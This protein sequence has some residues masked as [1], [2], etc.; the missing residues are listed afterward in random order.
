[1]RTVIGALI[2]AAMAASGCLTKDTT[3]TIY[4]ERDG[5]ITWS[6]EEH[7][8]RSDAKRA[9]ERTREER[10][11]L[12]SVHA[13][14]HPVAGAFWRLGP[15]DVRTDI[16]RAEPPAAV[17]TQARFAGIDAA[18]DRFAARAG[19]HAVS[20]LVHTGD[21]TTW[22]W[23]VAEDD[24][25]QREGDNAVGALGDVLDACRIVLASGRFI[26]AT[27]LDVTA[28]G[29]VATLR[30]ADLAGSGNPVRIVLSWTRL[31]SL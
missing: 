30:L 21:L 26:A 29:R 31:D 14:Q 10:E 24:S 12:A 18:L 8:I 15:L 7:T 23:S 17:V 3:H 4:I 28:D 27:G 5:T 2:A 9:A 20:T 11:F 1:M 22:T 6:V 19:L 25:P 16:V 13:G